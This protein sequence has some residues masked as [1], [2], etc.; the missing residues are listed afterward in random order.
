MNMKLYTKNGYGFSFII[1]GF[2][3]KNLKIQELVQEI[4]GYNI[5]NKIQPREHSKGGGVDGFLYERTLRCQCEL[6]WQWL[7]CQC[8]YGRQSDIFI[9]H[10]IKKYS[11]GN[12]PGQIPFI[13]L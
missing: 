5:P 11:Q 2:F 3:L 13:F 10:N 7:E 4:G 12:C 8:Q 6:E 1:S 9:P